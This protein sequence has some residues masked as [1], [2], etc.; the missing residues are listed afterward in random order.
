MLHLPQALTDG[1]DG[2]EIARELW[3]NDFL[4]GLNYR[5]AIVTAGNTKMQQ[6]KIDRFGIDRSL[7]ETII[8]ADQKEIAYQSLKEKFGPFLVIGDRIQNDLSPAKQA[9]GIT[10]HIRQG[11]GKKEPKNHPDVDYEIEEITELKGV[12]EKI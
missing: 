6:E 7:F 11:R 2:I 5:K 9:G 8:V 10:V 4:R 12:L 1:L 3:V